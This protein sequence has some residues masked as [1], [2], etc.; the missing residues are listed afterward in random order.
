MRNN[1]ILS[2]IIFTIILTIF[3]CK[4]EPCDDISCQNGGTCVEDA[5]GNASCNCPLGFAGD[6]CQ[7]PSP[8]DTIICQNGGVCTMNE[9]GTSYCI[10]TEGVVG[11]FCEIFCQLDCGDNGTCNVD[12]TGNLFCD[13]APG[14]SGE[15]CEFFDPC[16]PNVCSVNAIGCEDET[17]ICME[18]Y[19]GILC[20]ISIIGKYYGVYDVEMF[21]SNN[22][23]YTYGLRIEESPTD[24]N[25]LQIVGIDGTFHGIT[26][27]ITATVVST[28]EFIIPG[29]IDHF[30]NTIVSGDIIGDNTIGIRD[31]TNG[32][33]NIHFT[34]Y[35][36]TANAKVCE[37]TLI[38]R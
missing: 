10:C 8:C 7:L 27:T 12:S 33:L 6:L 23:Q 26:D 2:S 32:E 28:N 37:L 21:C 19:E 5:N 34:I 29:Q 24:T 30:G 35:Y 11:E 18:G 14:Y 3:A 1:H 38:P 25:A 9:D 15:S 31:E 20:D 36:A 22:G 4:S 17:C 16:N 13:C